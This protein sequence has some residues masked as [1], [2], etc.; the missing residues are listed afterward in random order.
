MITTKQVA[1]QLVAMCRTG[2][3]EEAKVEFFTEETMSIEPAEGLLPKETKGLQA[4]RQKAEL[5]ISMVD[6]FYGITIT[7]P[8]IAGDY[9][10][11]GWETDIKMKGE[12]RK[13]TN[14]ICLYRVNN[15]K[16]ISE[17]FFY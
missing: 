16:I 1:N 10:S 15:G 12:D 13:L 14:E 2:K 11:I 9:F 3:V 17:Q 5:F 4:I 8:V 6:E 7:E